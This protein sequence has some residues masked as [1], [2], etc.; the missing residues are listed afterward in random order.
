[1]T[2]P[3]RIFAKVPFPPP[4]RPKNFSENSGYDQLAH[5]ANLFASFR[6]SFVY[7]LFTSRDIMVSSGFRAMFLIVSLVSIWVVALD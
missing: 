3:I 6:R 2:W 1:M 5:E 4:P 7:K